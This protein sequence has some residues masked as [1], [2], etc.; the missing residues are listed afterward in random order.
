MCR[1]KSEGTMTTQKPNV[2]QCKGLFLLAVVCYLF[3]QMS[4]SK[5][6]HVVCFFI[7]FVTTAKKDTTEH[8]W[9]KWHN[10]SVFLNVNVTY[11]GN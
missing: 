8:Q 10:I 5:G 2:V 3:W 7:Y 1:G 6:M 11:V 4:S 9:L